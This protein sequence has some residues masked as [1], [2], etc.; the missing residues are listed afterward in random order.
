[1]VAEGGMSC[2][3]GGGGVDK[4]VWEGGG[5]GG[6]AVESLRE[7]QTSGGWGYRDGVSF[8]ARAPSSSQPWYSF[9]V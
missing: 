2:G 1:M 5:G 3:G 9:I 6:G 8:C 7:G 4:C